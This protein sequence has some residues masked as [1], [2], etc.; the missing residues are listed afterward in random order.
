MSTSENE[1]PAGSQT[2]VFDPTR[3]AIL[4]EMEEDGDT[5]MIKD[6]VVQFLEDITAVL[7]RIE[8]ALGAGDFSKIASEAHTIK[9][10]AATFGLYQVEKI[11]RELEASAKDSSKN[12][13]LPGIYKSLCEAFAAGRTA[14]E[15]YFAGR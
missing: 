9:G 8:A 7:A 6:I 3:L 1:N 12:T 2:P 4:L 14:L 10:S 11:A 15:A 5:S 13:S